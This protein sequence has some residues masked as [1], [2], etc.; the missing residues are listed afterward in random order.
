MAEAVWS[1][2]QADTIVRGAFAAL[3]GRRP[4]A[5]GLRFYVDHLVHGRLTVE[6]FLEQLTASAEFAE[7]R[8]QMARGAGEDAVVRALLARPA[9][10]ALS[11]RLA[12]PDDGARARIE[13]AIETAQLPAD[14]VPGQ[15]TYLAD[16]RRRFVELFHAAGVLTAGLPGPRILE[17]GPSVYTLVYERLWP[18]CRLV[19]ADRPPAPGEPGF[20]D[21]LGPRLA[22]PAAFPGVDL[23][24]DLSAAAARLDAHGP[25]DLVV[26]TEVL[27][28]LFRDPAEIVAFLLDRLAPGGSLYLTTPNALARGKLHAMG[29]GRNPQQMPP[30]T[31]TNQ[32]AH[33]HVREYTMRELVEIVEGAGGQVRALIFSACWDEPEYADYLVRH[34]GQRG[35]LTVVA[36][37]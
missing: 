30:P 13:A 37:R 4:D 11:E 35:N 18:H 24:G 36:A 8:L 29:T 14:L 12:N 16:H 34:P 33:H 5:E 1:E 3:L 22:G 20:G 32:D 25:F 26:F 7:R 27:E 28:H 31:G 9:V 6:A 21:L 10:A 23:L 17:F 15:A 19:S 2:H